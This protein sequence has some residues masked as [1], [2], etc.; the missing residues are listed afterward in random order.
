[1]GKGLIG[2]SHEIEMGRIWYLKKDLQKLEVRRLFLKLT[3]AQERSY[4]RFSS[5]CGVNNAFEF[6]SNP[7]EDRQ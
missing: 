6:D 3:D 2:A 5:V 4:D 7:S 1:M